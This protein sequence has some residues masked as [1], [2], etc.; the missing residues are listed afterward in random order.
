MS[1]CCR[2]AC[3]CVPPNSGVSKQ[4]NKPKAVIFFACFA[5]GCGE[6]GRVRAGVAYGGAGVAVAGALPAAPHCSKAFPVAEY[7]HLGQRHIGIVP[8]ASTAAHCGAAACCCRSSMGGDA[9]SALT[10]MACLRPCVMRG[11]TTLGFALG[12]LMAL[13]IPARLLSCKCSM[14]RKMSRVCRGGRPVFCLVDGAG[15]GWRQG[16]RSRV[17]AAHLFESLLCFLFV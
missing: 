13:E 6:L 17:C 9:M 4:R 12:P 14:Q 15:R 3:I 1:S 2:S 7:L 5:G 11:I 10:L 16:Q 8:T